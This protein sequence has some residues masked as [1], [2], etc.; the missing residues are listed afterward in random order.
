[1]K[2]PISFSRTF[3]L[4]ILLI[5][6]QA[7]A[8]D[9]L[10]FSL[11][12]YSG[13]NGMLLNPGEIADNRLGVDVHL[14]AVGFAFDN[15]FVGIADG[16][17]FGLR[18][19]NG[20]FSS[21]QEFKTMHLNDN[22]TTPSDLFNDPDR[23]LYIGVDVLGPSFMFQLRDGSA[24]AFHS[25]QRAIVNVDGFGPEA[26]KLGLEG[27]EFPELWLANNPN[28]FETDGFSIDAMIWRDFGL[29]YARPIPLMQDRPDQFF[30][31]GLT[32]KLYQGF[33]SAYAAGPDANYSFT[34]DDSLNI[35]TVNVGMTD[36]SDFKYG[37][38]TNFEVS[39]FNML[40]SGAQ[41]S[42]LGFDLGVVYEYR[43]D[44]AMYVAETKEGPKPKR[45][46]NKYKVKASLSFLDI[47]GIK[48]RR[49]RGNPGYGTYDLMNIDT[50]NWDLTNIKI[51]S[52]EDFDS[53]INV[54][55]PDSI[56]GAGNADYRMGAPFA[57]ALRVDYMLSQMFYL[58]LGTYISPTMKSDF[59]KVHGITNIN[60]TPRME[61]KWFDVGLPLAYSALGHFD[62]GLYTRLGPFYFG[63]PD[64]VRN[65]LGNNLKSLKFYGGVKIPIPLS[66]VP[67]SGDLD[68]DGILD[69][70]DNCIDVPGPV[71]NN[72]CPYGDRD[73]DAV[74]DNADACIDVPGPVEN[75]GCPYAD[76]DRDGVLD[77]SD[78]CIDVAGPVENNGCPYADKD[79]D[80]IFD[81]IDECIDVAGPKENGGC[82]WGDKDKDGVLDKDD[83]CIDLAGPADNKGCPL[84][85][86]DK[87]GLQDVDD[88]CPLT[89]G[90]IENRGCPMLDTAELEIIRLAF[91]NLE[92][93]VDKAIIRP[94]SYSN[95][96]NLAS[97][98]V[99]KP[100]Y[101]LLLAGHTDSDGSEEHNLILSKNRS[102]ATKQYL[103]ERG[104]DP[105]R[106]RV[107]YYGETKPIASNETAEGKQRNRRVEMTIEFE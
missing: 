52:I 56:H 101:R 81:V 95:L 46:Q 29:T 94:T 24:F 59:N 39:P 40:N 63:S 42:G 73:G 91:E 15:N 93:E 23:R 34:N 32:L 20:N 30:K 105:S 77:A 16:G 86:T 85:D 76:V 22:Y 70:A 38:T 7:K 37:H 18:A 71:E 80:G 26:A 67:E 55:F 53:L 89:P 54:T 6:F 64:F 48:F 2:H 100:T 8:Q 1:M 14:A 83:E 102:E 58:S 44:H 75:N 99:A 45:D 28:G 107:E 78:N 50:F 103:V 96:N 51:N 98:L 13:V 90:P 36:P 19:I 21:F 3:P 25:R 66:A 65:A 41:G 4:L 27:L 72:G 88:N 79:S 92:F 33:A 49:D 60:F 68:K 5:S 82:P 97:L 61:T 17:F 11:S 74:L 43:P 10:G 106:I 9:W 84:T 57:I 62:V 12:N 47:G 35:G 104:V 31:G 69:Y 87:D